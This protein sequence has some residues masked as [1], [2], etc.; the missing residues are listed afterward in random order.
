MLH[1]VLYFTVY[2]FGNE[3]LN[4]NCSVGQLTQIGFGQQ[5]QNGKTLYDAYVS[6]GFL[7]THLLNQ[8]VYVR[9]DGMLL[10]KQQLCHH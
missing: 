5:L 4:G 1:N 8:E 9:S 7:S 3:T 6:S 2:R 10:T